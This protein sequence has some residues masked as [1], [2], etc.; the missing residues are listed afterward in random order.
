MWAVLDA[1]VAA[2]GRQQKYTEIRETNPTV[3]P[4]RGAERDVGGGDRTPGTEDS[5]AGGRGP[6]RPRSEF[7]TPAICEFIIPSP[8]PTTGTECARPGGGR[9]SV[10]QSG[11]NYEDLLVTVV[12]RVLLT[13]ASM[14]SGPATLPMR[15][16]KVVPFAPS[17]IFA[18]R[19][20]AMSTPGGSAK[21]SSALRSSVK[22]RPPPPPEAL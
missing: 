21:R 12:N 22:G 11:S 1:H 13:C 7:L 10:R 18:S 3:C 9:R 16:L 2:T 20:Q 4:P 6:G 8:T 15:A 19:A 5:H 17:S 14:S